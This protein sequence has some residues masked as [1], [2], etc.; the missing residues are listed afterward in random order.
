MRLQKEYEIRVGQP[1]M[2]LRTDNFQK[3]RQHSLG[4][5]QFYTFSL[6]ENA[7]M[8]QAVPDGSVDILFER[9]GNQLRSFIGGT[10]LQAKEWPL[11]TD[12]WYFGV[13]FLPGQCFLPEGLSAKELVNADIEI[14]GNA[15]GDHL[16]EQLMEA[17]TLEE[18]ARFFL[19]S[20]EKQL[21]GERTEQGWNRLERY[22]R[23]RIYASG[24]KVPMKTLVEETGYSACYI[25]RNFERVHGVAPKM[26]E[27]FIRFQ[28]VL[29]LINHKADK[30]YEE[31]AL[32]C[33]YYDQ[34][35]MIHE[36]KRF[37]GLT[38]E[39]YR[40]VTAKMPP[41]MLE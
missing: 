32:E 14:S 33:G 6:G 37:A 18:Q 34:A 15:Y 26:F 11:E 2:A 27:K 16:A 41:A 35:H 21:I 3:M 19:E 40:S 28:N 22:V 24:G 17:R 12:S 8:L 13:R 30:S 25:R 38:P 23:A 10:V 20:Y 7:D 9:K 31:L 39:V 29:H 5:T 4:I 1:Y 36:F